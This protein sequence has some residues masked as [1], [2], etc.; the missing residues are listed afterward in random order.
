MA[1]WDSRPATFDAVMSLYALL[2]VPL[3]DQRELIP[4]LANSLAP[5]CYLLAIVGHEQWTGVEDYMGAPMFWDHADAGTYLAW[6]PAAGLAVLWHRYI[7][8]GTSGHTLLL[9]QAG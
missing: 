3:N 8:E 2:H 4:R 6:L 5:G 9:A 1:T 7:P